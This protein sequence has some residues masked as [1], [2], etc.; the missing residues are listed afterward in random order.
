MAGNEAINKGLLEK[1]AP[2]KPTLKPQK[3]AKHEAHLGPPA[4]ASAAEPVSSRC[5]IGRVATPTEGPISHVCARTCPSEAAFKMIPY[6]SAARNVNEYRHS[7]SF[8]SKA[9]RLLSNVKAQAKDST[10]T[11]ILTLFAVSRAKHKR[12]S[13]DEGGEK[14][15]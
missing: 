7:T 14:W 10:I 5:M 3:R 4:P 1:I 8:T 2:G 12:T 6:F 13:G 15:M 9:C 11:P